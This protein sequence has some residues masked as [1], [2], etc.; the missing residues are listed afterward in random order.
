M[1]SNLE[2][3]LKGLFNILTENDRVIFYYVGHGFNDGTTNYLST[4]D[5]HPI[6][7]KETAISLQDILIK[8]IL[9]SRCN[10]AILFID[11]C[12]KS[13][14][15]ENERNLIFNL[16]PNTFNIEEN[17]NFYSATFLSCQSGES[18][19][20]CDNLSHGIWTYHLLEALN[21]NINEILYQNILTDRSLVDYLT[22]SVSKYV[23]DELGYVQ[24][25]KAILDS[26][27][28]YMLCKL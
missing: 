1:K 26:D 13:I 2:Y 22:K 25:P 9:S 5:M 21:G 6:N 11:A 23:K 14:V 16:D 10:S 20:S 24:N 28:E 15:K 19:Y 12:A 3:D 7:I 4:Y 27:S 17:K 8:P 18:S